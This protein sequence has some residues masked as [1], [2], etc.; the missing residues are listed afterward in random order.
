[1]NAN[2]STAADSLL[3][4]LGNR[5]R[6]KVG[7][8]LGSGL[9]GLADQISDA[10][11]ID[12]ESI[13]GFVRSTAG[14][15]RGQLIFGELQS[16]PVVA[17]AGR[18]HRY[19]GWTND[20]AAFPVEVMHAIGADSLIVSNAA[21]GV[22]PKLAVGDIV[23]LKD[24]L[25]WMGG[26]FQFNQA[27]LIQKQGK[28]SSEVIGGIN[29]GQIYDQPMAKIAQ[30]SA[31]KAGF[32]AN[33]GTYLATLGPTYETRAEYRMM[34]KLG[35][36]VVG[37]STVPEVLVANA[38]GMRVLG[39]SMVS[40]VADPDRPNVANHEEV[41]LAGQA[42]GAKMETIVRGVLRRGVLRNCPESTSRTSP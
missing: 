1:M 7:I 21:G 13:P 38:L 5:P 10:L 18:F 24:H 26:T 22:S 30:E 16:V 40:N 41:L 12:Y 39:L 17:M 2:V 23:I 32:S 20:Q 29:R 9:G 36:D 34:R 31:M 4:Q 25:N 6:P 42:A 11:K 3:Q 35:A 33:F 37:M 28:E 8:I 15:H 14:G 27:R 19:E